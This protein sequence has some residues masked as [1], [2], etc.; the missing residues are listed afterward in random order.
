MS[1]ETSLPLS[2]FGLHARLKMNHAC[3]DKCCDLITVDRLGV[4]AAPY[5]VASITWFQWVV[6]DE[7]MPMKCEQEGTTDDAVAASHQQ[8]KWYCSIKNQP[9]SSI[10]PLIHLVTTTQ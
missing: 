6:T 5:N 8:F 1:K 2:H 4:A 10:N 9:H 7:G 3:C